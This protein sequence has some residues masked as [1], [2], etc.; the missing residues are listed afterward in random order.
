MET[1]SRVYNEANN[2]I[3]CGI[4]LELTSVERTKLGH[5]H[6]LSLDFVTRIFLLQVNFDT[7]KAVWKGH[8]L[9]RT[10]LF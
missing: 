1:R 3:C 4:K 10:F 6:K 2:C 7:V 8:L 9:N 5:D